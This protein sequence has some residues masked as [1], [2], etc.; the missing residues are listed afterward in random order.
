MGYASCLEDNTDKVHDNWHMRSGYRP[1]A[2]PKPVFVAASPPLQ[3]VLSSVVIPPRPR[4]DR[5]T[6]AGRKRPLLEKHV[7]A[8][9]ELMPGSRWRH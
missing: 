5:E 4:P 3:P 7:I 2:Q 1:G 6:I 8:L 9:Y